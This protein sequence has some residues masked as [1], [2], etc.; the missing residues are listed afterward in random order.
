LHTVGGILNNDEPPEASFD[1][2]L[3]EEDSRQM[4][5]YSIPLRSLYAKDMENLY[6]AGRDISVS[7]VALGSTRL[8]ATCAVIGQAAG[9]AA[10][11]SVGQKKLPKN[12]K[13]ADIQW[14]QQQLLR[15][16]CYIPTLVNQD[17]QDLARGA[18]VRVSSHAPLH[19]PEQVK[20]G[21][22]YESPRQKTFCRSNLDVKR[23]Q[24]FPCTTDYLEK[25]KVFIESDRSQ[26]TVL[27]VSLIVAHNINDFD[28]GKS[29]REKTVPVDPFSSGWIEIDISAK[30]EPGSLLWLQ[31]ASEEQV[32]WLYSDN[33][34]TGTVSASRIIKNHRP[35][36]GSYALKVFPE[37]FPYKGENL[38]SGQ[39]RP[40]KW[41]NIWISDPKQP[42]P[43]WV[44][45]SFAEKVSLNTVQLVFDSNL[46]IAH[47]MVPGLYRAKECVKAYTLYYRDGDKWTELLQEADN[48][49]R[50]RIHRFPRVATDGLR[51]EIQETNG[52]AS[53]RLYELRAYLE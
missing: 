14:I 17:P 2:N 28:S 13:T 42:L 29:I 19:F 10:A 30:V 46:N 47:S 43:A 52:D 4:N 8:M 38:L 51:L 49:Q 45:Y 27:N 1:G 32:Y 23:A 35:Q 15:K 3:Q 5:I 6:M 53:A 24:L 36:K 44:E 40:E 21:Y 37:M 50:L 9:T 31:I 26:A 33:P 7:H 16:D 22:E 20:R 39:T 34:P 12:F 18:Q 41:T 25:I 11:Y 48:W